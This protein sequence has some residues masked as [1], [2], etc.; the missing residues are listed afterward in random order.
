MTSSTINPLPTCSSPRLSLSG[1]RPSTIAPGDSISAAPSL[2]S[3]SP[4]IMSDLSLNNTANNALFPAQTSNGLSEVD[5]LFLR[6]NDKLEA[7]GAVS[8]T[9]FA[10]RTRAREWGR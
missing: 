8:R 1:R 7:A 4:S 3:S 6:L 2:A 10:T 5:E 9:G